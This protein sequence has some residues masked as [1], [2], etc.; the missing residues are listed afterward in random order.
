MKKAT[1]GIPSSTHREIWSSNVF[2]RVVDGVFWPPVSHFL[3]RDLNGG[4]AI[5]LLPSFCTENRIFF[6]LGSVI[7]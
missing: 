4:K 2:F 5:T 1:S 7:L 6:S 3:T